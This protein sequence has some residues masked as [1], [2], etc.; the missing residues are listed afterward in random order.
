MKTIRSLLLLAC[1]IYS[2]CSLSAPELKSDH[3]VLGI[4]PRDAP[5]SIVYKDGKLTGTDSEVVR[6]AAH[7]AGIN[8]RFAVLPWNRVQLMVKEGSLDGAAVGYKKAERE[9][10]GIFTSTP[11]NYVS[12]SLFVKKGSE[13]T[14]DNI[15]DLYGK[16]LGKP[17]GFLIYDD[18]DQAAKEEKLTLIEVNSRGALMHMLRLGRIDAMVTLTKDTLYELALTATNDIVVLPNHVTKPE[19]SYIWFSK[20]ANLSPTVLIK[21]NKALKGLAADGSL[22]KI[23][24]KYGLNYLP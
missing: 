18:M 4:M 14:F 3:L 21:F 12:Y 22:Q 5:P 10:Y 2:V 16:T 7:R 1:L 17:L 11:I 24:Q 9:I 6:A 13:F 23:Y 8:I 20:A 15:K 19:G